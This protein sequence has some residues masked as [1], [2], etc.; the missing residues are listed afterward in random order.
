MEPKYNIVLTI[1]GSDSSGGAG[2]QADIKAIS[3]CGGYAAS[4]ITALTAQNTCKVEDVSVVADSFV[5]K[6]I[7]AVA[8][9]LKVDALK[10]GMLPTKECVEQVA[11]AIVKYNFKNVVLD[12]VMISTSGHT[13][14]SQEAI[15][16]IK[17]LL[18]PL[19]DIVTPNIPEAEF[20]TGIKIDSEQDFE[21]VANSFFEMGAKAVLIKAGH[22]Q[23]DELNDFLF[24]SSGKCHKYSYKKIDT[25]NT[26]GTGCTLSSATA[27]F[28]GHGFEPMQAVAKA[29]DYIHEAIASGAQYKI[30]HGFGPVHHFYKFWK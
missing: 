27:T 2:I 9:D 29:E 16:A 26:H 4:V 21:T 28:L 14:I 8:E 22:M 5:E 30:G 12:P 20:I 24:E 11:K 18:F 19:A 7:D 6:Q 1:A 17:K 25:Q 13:L 23:A 3:A 15:E 10:L